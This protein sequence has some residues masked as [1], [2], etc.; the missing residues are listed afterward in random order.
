MLAVTRSE[1]RELASLAGLPFADDPMNQ[2]L[3]LT[4]NRVRHQILP[5]MRALNPRVDSAIARAAQVLERDAVFL[6]DLARLYDHDPLPLSVLTTLPRPLADRLI[7]HVLKRH[8]I[9][10]TADRMERFWSVATGASQ[11]QDLAEGMV[12]RRDGALIVIEPD[13]S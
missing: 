2:D 12:A 3:S 11:R 1:T 9:A 10:P 7:L 13:D 4:R 6:E 5:L 8:G